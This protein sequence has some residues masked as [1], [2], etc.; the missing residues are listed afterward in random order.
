MWKP[1]T[2]GQRASFMRRPPLVGGDAEPSA[3]RDV[4]RA[5]R[6]SP[7]GR[8]RARRRRGAT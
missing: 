8:F 4:T 1:S 2:R 6:L 5:A 7:R 3:G